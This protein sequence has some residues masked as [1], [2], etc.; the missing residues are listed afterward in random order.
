MILARGLVIL[1]A[2]ICA[3]GIFTKHIDLAATSSRRPIPIYADNNR[4]IA[5]ALNPEFHVVI[6][7][8]TIRFHRL[9]EEEI[10]IGL[11]KKPL[12]LISISSC[13]S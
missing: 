11:F 8:I 2:A 12:I 1:S 5:L 6:K 10:G 13:I 3:I 7:H 4:A 9:R